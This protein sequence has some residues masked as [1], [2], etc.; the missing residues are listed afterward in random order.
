MHS[1]ITQVMAAQYEAG[2]KMASQ[3][4]REKRDMT[5]I[6]QAKESLTPYRSDPAG[7]SHA[8]AAQHYH[9]LPRTK[10]IEY[11]EAIEVLEARLKILTK[12]RDI[13]HE[14]LAH[15]EAESRG[16]V[17][18]LD[19]MDQQIARLSSE[20]RMAE[21]T[22]IGFKTS[23]LALSI[24]LALSGSLSYQNEPSI[25]VPQV[26][27]RT[28]GLFLV[29]SA[30]PYV[31]T[32][33]P[34]VLQAYKD[35]LDIFI[36]VMA[37]ASVPNDSNTPAHQLATQTETLENRIRA[38]YET[39]S[40]TKLKDPGFVSR[41]AKKYSYPGGPEALFTTLNKKYA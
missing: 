24:A 38:F 8:R 30:V 25:L 32:L 2:A 31:V 10:L 14:S 27:C 40:P 23:I 39:H 15:S 19:N 5:I 26:I 1:S 33:L 13:L 34:A 28:V 17:K 9:S 7:S 29:A 12:D 37:W 4:I 35:F 16:D 18:L 22:M 20:G 36:T 41:I 6:S 21:L 3:K 11:L